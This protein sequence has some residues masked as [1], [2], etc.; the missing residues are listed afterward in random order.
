MT[1]ITSLNIEGKNY[2]NILKPTT[3]IDKELL[4]YMMEQ[5][6]YKHVKDDRNQCHYKCDVHEPDKDGIMEVSISRLENDGNFKVFNTK[7]F[8]KGILL[9]P[10]FLSNEWSWDTIKIDIPSIFRP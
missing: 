5:T 6:I 9:Q 7:C 1:F 3:D 8:L 4:K 2:Y 10:Q